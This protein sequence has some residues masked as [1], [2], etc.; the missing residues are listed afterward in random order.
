[1][2]EILFL[3]L[4]IY[5]TMIIQLSNLLPDVRIFGY[6]RWFIYKYILR[7]KIGHKCIFKPGVDIPVDGF[8]NITIGDVSYI[9]K[10]VRFDCKEASITIGSRVLVGSFTS[11]HTGSH[12][13]EL[14]ENGLR[15][16]TCKPIVVEDEVWLGANVV[17]LSGITIGR[18]AVV[19][20]GSVVTK[21]IPPNTLMAGVPAKIIR[22]INISDRVEL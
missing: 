1:M 18:G 10:G 4:Y 13:I 20:A 6:G 17:V 11:F 2:K 7:L 19:A 5:R 8:R 15:P 22:V 9:N 21:D 3:P 12:A 16:F 14:D